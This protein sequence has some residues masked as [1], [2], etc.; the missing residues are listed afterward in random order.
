MHSPFP[1]KENRMLTIARSPKISAVS[2]I[3]FLLLTTSFMTHNFNRSFLL[4]KS[5]CSF[6]PGW[7]MYQALQ[8]RLNFATVFNGSLKKLQTCTATNMKYCGA[9]F[10]R[11]ELTCPSCATAHHVHSAFH[12]MFDW[13]TALWK[14]ALKLLRRCRWEGA[15]EVMQTACSPAAQRISTATVWAVRS[16]RQKFSHWW[17]LLLFL[18]GIIS[19]TQL[20][21]QKSAFTW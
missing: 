3:P 9:V 13:Q 12:C 16:P 20:H 19:S 11:L 1:R 6:A 21:L 10:S 4:Q 7:D 15:A 2:Q 18:S 8:R 14:T 5:S 17:A